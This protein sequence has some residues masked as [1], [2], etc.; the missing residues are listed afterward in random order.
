MKFSYGPHDFSGLDRSQEQC[1]LL[2][3]GLGGYQSTTGAFSVN[4]CDQGLLVAAVQAPNVRRTLLHRVS[5]ILTAD[6]ENSYLSTQKFADDTPPEEGY[7]YLTAFHW[8]HIPTWDY[9]VRGVQVTRRCAMEYGSNTAALRYVITNRSKAPCTLRV[10]PA[11]LFADKGAALKTAPALS[12]AE[13]KI[14]SGETD[15]WVRS[16]GKLRVFPQTQQCLAYE[17]DGK[18][19]RAASGVA[20]SCCTFAKTAAPGQTAVLELVFSAEPIAKGADEIISARLARQKALVEDSGFHRDL[21]RQLAESADAFLVRRDSTDGLSMIAGYPFFGDW[22]RDTMIALPGCCLATG[23]YEE[24][25]SILRTFLAYEWK[26][27]IPNLFPEGEQKPMYNTVD[28]ALLLI[29]DIWLYIR[30]SGDTEFAGE[31]WPIM[32]RIV[33][34][35]Q[36]GTEF[37]IYMDTDGL[38]HAGAGK[39]QV[40]WMD[41]CVN[42]ILPTPRHGKPVEINAYWY[43]ALRIMASLAPDGERAAYD[44]LADRVQKSFVAKFWREEAGGL[45]DVVSGTASDRQIRCNQIWAVTMP[46]TMLT[47]AQERQVVETVMRHLYTPLGLRTLSPED[48]DFR[49]VYEG[50]QM[51]RDL[52]YHQGTVWPFPMGA[53]YMAYWKVYGGNAETAEVI[54]HM[55]EPLYAALREGCTGQ[56]PEVYDGLCP[57]VSKGCFAQAW[58]V[59]ELLRVCRMLEEN[60]R[61]A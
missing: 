60:E 13:G 30:Q 46:F 29:N 15:L 42:G 1:W 12:C 45:R 55:L 43:S 58:S 11:F 54:W 59:C 33:A 38:I 48:P 16:D 19:G 34:G 14:R 10:T 17:E 26:G 23:R 61:N 6:G 7:R 53:F 41:V 28:A 52:A 57:T 21:S 22:G 49:G 50:G 25:K 8:E 9:F 47:R 3:N 51:E 56:L 39:A 18:N 27:L 37:A 32:K 2:T 20:S 31:A 5:E 35:Y 24:A 40:T 44:A 4:R 36:K